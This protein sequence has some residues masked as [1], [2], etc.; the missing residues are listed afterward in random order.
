[1]ALRGLRWPSSIIGLA[2]LGLLLARPVCAQPVNPDQPAGLPVISEQPATQ[3]PEQSST[4]PAP[5]IQLGNIRSL[6]GQLPTPQP[7]GPTRNWT[8]VPTLSVQEMGTDNVFDTPNGRLAD[9]ITTISPGI[10][11]NGDTQRLHVTLNY[12]PSIQLFA[13][14]PGQNNIAQNL[15]GQALAE[16]IPSWLF[17]NV[18]AYAAQ[19]AISG[20]YAPGGTPVLTNQ[21]RADTE[22]FT[23]SPYLSHTFDGTGTAQLG[24]AYNY[25]SQTGAMASLSSSS[26][27]F[28]VPNDVSSNEEFAK[29]STGGNFGR[30]NDKVLLD[31][32][33]NTGYGIV[34]NS[35]QNFYIDALA[36][37]L[38]R[39]LSLVVEGGYEQ[40]DYPNGLPPI[41]IN[42]PVWGF[43]FKLQPNPDSTIIALYRHLYGVNAPYLDANFALTAR[44]RI[45]ASY[46]DTVGT[47]TQI[48]QNILSET[49]L[50]QNGTP[51]SSQTG[52]PVLLS[53]QQFG[54]Q[55]GLTRQKQ[56]SLTMTTSLA[57]DTFSLNAYY[58]SQSLLSVGPGTSGYS[59]S[60]L[61]GGLSWTHELT[62]VASGTAYLQYGTVT[63][64]VPG[65]P[66]SSS[67][68]TF[69]GS[70]SLA[71][72][73]TE[74]LTGTVQYI[75]TN[76]NLGTFGAQP[77][78]LSSQTALQNIVMVGIQKRF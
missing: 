29:F 28:F 30:L 12:D 55:T 59:Q 47:P 7:T 22:S 49:T 37:A 41:S 53:N 60:G 67:G 36:Y 5:E 75:L 45:Y 32:T 18:Q 26:L 66:G 63:S 50:G 52:A 17:V 35:R 78:G 61:S 56:L 70:L 31:A 69:T 44:T 46:S 42:D 19:Q 38:D 62:P 39:S 8:I 71:Y 20:G 72:R 4:Q 73:F 3:P 25:T 11:I 23:L 1:M 10:L 16:V 48:L 33:Q 43:G 13:F 14:T 64:S 57:R 54:L 27:P 58:Q 21:N 34:Q 40:I 65:M 9:I 51:V 77:F 68:Q 6:L 15:N 2:A 76:A 24:Y 74:S